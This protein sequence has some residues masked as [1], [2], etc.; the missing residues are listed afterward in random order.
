VAEDELENQDP[1]AVRDALRSA[2][3]ELRAA[4]SLLEHFLELGR[5]DWSA[6][7]IRTSTFS[8]RDCLEALAERVRPSA[9]GK[10]LELRLVPM[11][12]LRVHTDQLKLERIVLSLLSNAVRFSERGQVELAVRQEANSI[13][14]DVSDHGIG[15]ASEELV[16]IFDEFYQ[17]HNPARDRT[18]GYGLGLAIARRVANRLGGEIVARSIVGQGSRFSV[19]FPREYLRPAGPDA[20]AVEVA[21]P[22]R[23]GPDR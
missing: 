12:D 1:Q 8:L 14:V 19:V 20:R 7:T 22:T 9:E 6:D 5:L 3:V 2:R 13:R 10:G 4:T 23:A 17:T 18:K 16:R 15:I 11:D 21:A